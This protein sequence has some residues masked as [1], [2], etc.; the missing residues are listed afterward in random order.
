MPS[1]T[2]SVRELF[3]TSISNDL[4]EALLTACQPS[5]VIQRSFVARWT[6][7]A[8]AVVPKGVVIRKDDPFFPMLT[9]I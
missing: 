2:F 6:S 4:V 3:G 8:S 7:T 5:S 1:N 9:A